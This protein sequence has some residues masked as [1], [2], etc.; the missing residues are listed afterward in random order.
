VTTNQNNFATMQF[1]VNNVVMAQA[2][3]YKGAVPMYYIRVD[4]VK[5]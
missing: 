2:V 4:E 3:Y 5:A 1:I